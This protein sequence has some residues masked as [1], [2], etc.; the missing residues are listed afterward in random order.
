LT[1]ELAEGG[2]C[3]VRTKFDGRGGLTRKL[4]PF[5]CEKVHP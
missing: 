2:T 5:A 3:A 1:V 4:G